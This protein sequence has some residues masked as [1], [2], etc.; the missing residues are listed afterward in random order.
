MLSWTFQLLAQHADV[1]TKLRQ[2]ILEEFGTYDQPVNLT[3][4]QLKS[5]KYLQS[6]ISETLRLFPVVPVNSRECL[7]DF[8]TLPRGG[9]PDGNA[10]IFIRKGQEVG[11]SV[12]AMHRAPDIWGQDAEKFRSERWM[13]GRR[14]DWEFPPFN[15]GP[16]ICIGWR[17]ALTEGSYVIVRM[18]QRFGPLKGI[19]LPERGF[20]KHRLDLTNRPA[21]PVLV[22]LELGKEQLE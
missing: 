14:V 7:V 5:C 17:F 19:G 2:V 22:V 10:P 8:T 12:H 6:C 18:V 3:F 21:N 15:G 16:R 1:Y 9:G 11:Y 4:G 13:E 20:E